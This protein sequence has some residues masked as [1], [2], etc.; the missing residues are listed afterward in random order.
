M[1]HNALLS[2]K[3]MGNETTQ[4]V[5]LVTKKAPVPWGGAGLCLALLS[6]FPLSLREMVTWKAG[7]W[8]NGK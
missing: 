1:W 6:P 7:G 2:K 8:E 5:K 4:L 3:C